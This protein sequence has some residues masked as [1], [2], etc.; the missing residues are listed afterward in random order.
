MSGLLRGIR[1]VHVS[2]SKR[3]LLRPDWDKFWRFCWAKNSRENG[4]AKWNSGVVVVEGG[5]R[6][7]CAHGNWGFFAV[8]DKEKAGG[9]RGWSFCLCSS[10]TDRA[11]PAANGGFSS[12]SLFH[13]AHNYC[14][15]VE[16][17]VGFVSFVSRRIVVVER[18]LAFPL[19][20]HIAVIFRVFDWLF[21][22]GCF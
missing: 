8:T 2:H 14:T 16:M 10:F 17:L 18:C 12:P 13:Q 9:G 5:E 21:F 1:Q 4:M 19:N 15:W 3:S 7:K 11:V 6:K 22:S 20:A